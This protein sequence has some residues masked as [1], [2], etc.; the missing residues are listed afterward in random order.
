MMERYVSRPLA[1]PAPSRGLRVHRADIVFYGVDH[2]GPSYEARV[3]FNAPSATVRTT[4]QPAQGY[5][6]AFNIFGHGGCDEGHCLVGGETRD[7]FDVR[8]PHP[9]TPQTKTVIVTNAF[10]RLKGRNVV[11]TVVA[12][13]PGPNGAEPADVLTFDHVRL[14]IYE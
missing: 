1:L 2:S 8:P 5:A 4:L 11:I 10:Q 14:L 13:V 7:E 12:V 3:F 9:L 6:G